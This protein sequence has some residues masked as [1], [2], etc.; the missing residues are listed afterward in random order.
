RSGFTL[1]EM[2]IVL[3]VIATVAAIFVPIAL[4]LSDRNQV[5]KGASMLENA[6][7]LA[8]ARAVS[9]KRPNGVRIS[10]T[11]SNL[12]TLTSGSSFAWYDELQ[13]IEDPGDYVNAWGWGL[14]TSGA[15]TVEQ[16]FWNT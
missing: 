13:Y 10:L 6:L 14:T 1:V 5:P 3:G 16:P 15:I 11:A 4:N 2:L 9:E 12:R 7:A 8:K